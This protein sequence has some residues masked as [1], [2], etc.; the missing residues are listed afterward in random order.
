MNANSNLIGAGVWVWGTVT[1]VLA[2][3]ALIVVIWS[4]FYIVR[5][6]DKYKFSGDAPARLI[7][8]F[9][10]LKDNGSLVAGILGFSGLAWSYFFKAFHDCIK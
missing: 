2:V 4:A 8:M 9:Y 5:S 10:A 7:G 6:D 1:V 3:A